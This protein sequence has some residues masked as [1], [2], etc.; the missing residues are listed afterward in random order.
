MDQFRVISDM[1]MRDYV[2]RKN[3]KIE[4]VFLKM[5]IDLLRNGGGGIF[6]S[7]PA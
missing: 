1:K 4:M 5:A 2:S 3:A 6:V 7:L